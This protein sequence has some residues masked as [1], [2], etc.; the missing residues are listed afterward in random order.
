MSDAPLMPQATAV[1]LVEHTAL[2]FDQIA[3]FCHLHPLS[4]KAIA[5]GELGVGVRGHD[6][7]NAGQLSR[8]EIAKAEADPA[9]RLHLA[10]SKVRLPEVKKR[11]RGPRYT[12]LSR[13]QD[14][15]NAILWL[16][17]S[18]PE[19]KDAAIIR[20]VGTTKSTIAAIRDRTHWNVSQLNPLDPVS[21]GLCGQVDLDREVAAAA[22]DRPKSLEPAGPTLEP[23]EDTAPRR[24]AP[25]TADEVFGSS[26][27]RE[28]DD[29]EAHVDIEQV[30]GVK[31]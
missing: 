26:V 9:F 11:T 7:V 8:E 21:L 13:R 6:P 10:T 25:R 5:D 1:W 28:E 3:A 17:R 2:T 18:H 12:P 15:P 24:E 31:K 19:L 16:V 30:F 20:L 27:P 4:V 22:K 29:E 23:V 14:R